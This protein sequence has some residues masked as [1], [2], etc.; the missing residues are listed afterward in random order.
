MNSTLLAVAAVTWVFWSCLFAVKQRIEQMYAAGFGSGNT[1]ALK[2]IKFLISAGFF[3]FLVFFFV[4]GW[5]VSWLEALAAV[6]GGFLVA[7]M[8][9]ALL[10][11]LR[12]NLGP[13]NLLGKL[14]LVGLPAGAIALWFVA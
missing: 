5:R 9:S 13:V 8:F 14:G 3:N 7:L 2:A 4:H 12:W 11:V 6:A 1:S 10:G